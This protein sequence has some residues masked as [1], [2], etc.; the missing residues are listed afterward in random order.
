M[1][2]SDPVP[3]YYTGQDYRWE[4]PACVKTRAEVR[5]LKKWKIGKFVES[6]KIFLFFKRLVKEA[7]TGFWDGPLGVGNLLP[8]A[9]THTQ[10]EK[11]HYETPP[12]GYHY[13]QRRFERKSTR[14]SSRKLF[15]SQPIPM[16]PLTAQ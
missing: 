11:L 2:A 16:R 3:C 7:M 4:R 10:G 6:G 15:N 13:W 12:A 1:A 9:R 5:E 14:V 8:F